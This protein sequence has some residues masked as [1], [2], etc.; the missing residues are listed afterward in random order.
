M[1]V[2]VDG[3]SVFAAADTRLLNVAN[4][5]CSLEQLFAVRHDVIK[6]CLRVK[7]E[8]ERLAVIQMELLS[9]VLWCWSGTS[10]PCRV[11]AVC[12]YQVQQSICVT[13]QGPAEPRRCDR[14]S[15]FLILCLTVT[16]A[17][18]T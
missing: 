8:Q 2:S 13:L 16:Q 12:N 10:H 9:N 1:C 17:L 15:G 6:D 11:M 5:L 18:K 4:M 7:A 14:K 3:S